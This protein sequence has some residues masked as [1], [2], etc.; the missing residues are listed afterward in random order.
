MGCCILGFD[1][2]Y[3]TWERA[4][5]L[6]IS[7]PSSGSKLSLSPTS[8]G[9]L[10]G[11]IFDPLNISLLPASAGFLLRSLI[12]SENGSDMLLRNVGFPPN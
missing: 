3:D 5:V 1:A 2:L 7:P 10:L 9:Y 6:E 11:L 4:Y 12:D 8:V